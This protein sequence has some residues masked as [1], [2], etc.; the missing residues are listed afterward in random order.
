MSILIQL[1]RLFLVCVWIFFTIVLVVGAY[2]LDMPWY[3]RVF[4]LV[5][6]VLS[7]YNTILALQHYWVE[8]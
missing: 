8:E 7:S 6:A 3:I 2:E 5:A 1:W 4:M